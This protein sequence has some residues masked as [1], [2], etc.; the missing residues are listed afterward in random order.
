MKITNAKYT[1][2]G[3]I[4]ATI[5]GQE[6]TIPDDIT[7]RHRAALVEWEVAGNS[8][9]P[10]VTPILTPEQLRHR[11]P[12]KSLVELRAIMRNIST[13]VFSD[14]IYAA[15]IN[16]MID[17]IADLDLQ[18]EGRDYFNLGQYAER[19][20][21]WVDILGANAGL[22]PEEIDVHWMA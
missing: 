19:I 5:D 7:N 3:S 16:A 17:A 15:D 18:E 13:P 12:H 21:P 14:G 1:E 11:M 4:R 22:T 6:M 10:Y 9:E 20:N 2:Q 8:I